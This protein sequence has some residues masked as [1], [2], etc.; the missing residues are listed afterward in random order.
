[1]KVQKKLWVKVIIYR[2]H[3]LV[4]KQWVNKIYY[5]TVKKIKDSIEKEAEIILLNKIQNL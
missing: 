2:K 1:M 3:D 4:C 5:G